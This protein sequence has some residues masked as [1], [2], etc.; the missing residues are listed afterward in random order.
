MFASILFSPLS[1]S[2][3]VGKIKIEQIQINFWCRISI[4]KLCL[5]KF[6]TLDYFEDASEEGWKKNM[7]QK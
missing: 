4:T 2:F 1:P 6:K 7:G 3:L 5:G